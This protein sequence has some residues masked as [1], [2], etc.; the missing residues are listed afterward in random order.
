MTE[1]ARHIEILLL[2]NDC[3]IVPGFGGFM[4]HHAVS[5]YDE[6]E[7]LFLPP[8]RTL[9]FNPQLQIN[10][11]LLAQSY[12]EAYDVSYPEALRRIED[13]VNELRQ[14]IA[15]EGECELQ[16][17]GVISV[18]EDGN[19]DFRP[20]L[21][22]ILTP[23]LYALGCFEM[24]RL[25]NFKEVEDV[26][27]EIG[28]VKM[29]VIPAVEVEMDDKAADEVLE[30]AESA[31]ND[32]VNAVPDAEIEVGDDAELV[33]EEHKSNVITL[34]I[35][36][37]RHIATAA[38]VLI[39]FILVSM[40]F[41]DSTHQ[42]VKLCSIDSNMLTRIMPKLEVEGSVDDLIA[43]DN[44]KEEEV[45]LEEKTPAAPV[46]EVVKE[47][48]PSQNFVIVL[49]CGVPQKN[50][51]DYV[52]KLKTMGV[53]NA[54]VMHDRSMIRVVCGGFATEKEARTAVN[55]VRMKPGLESAWVMDTAK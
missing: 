26:T 31:L 1:L 22:G 10:D 53:D 11:S 46:E 7:A 35:D 29:P 21:S 16:D 41:G 27:G 55:I 47:A 34:R 51:E 43:T 37:L 54:R 50:A 15:N 38:V 19:Y 20:C 8:S 24:E 2:N 13:D 25:K 52:E 42:S 12:I 6:N 9:G 44:A 39:F 23:S 36:T 17:I 28:A 32:D 4:A 5:V 14:R 45:V 18:N 40:P 3:V 33:E 48:Q 30:E 49:A